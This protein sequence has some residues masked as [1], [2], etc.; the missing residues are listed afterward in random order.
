[1]SQTVEEANYVTN[2]RRGKKRPAISQVLDF[3]KWW[4]EMDVKNAGIF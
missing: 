3:Q 1:M 4:W 2:R